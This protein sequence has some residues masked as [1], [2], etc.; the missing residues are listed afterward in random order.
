MFEID[1]EA[2]VEFA[3]QNGPQELCVLDFAPSRTIV[4]GALSQEKPNGL[5]R[6]CWAFPLVSITRRSI[7]LRA[8][9]LCRL[10]RYIAIRP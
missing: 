7:V 5:E 2:D 3:R 8:T 1:I 10:P 4:N 9:A 6:H